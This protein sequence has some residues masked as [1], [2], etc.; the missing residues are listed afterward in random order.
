M[1]VTCLAKLH[2]FCIGE[3]NEALESRALDVHTKVSNTEGY[4]TLE[5]H[6]C[7]KKSE[8]VALPAQLIG[9]RDHF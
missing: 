5:A 1:L 4:V 8:E 2:N 6:H 7:S 9:G 3:N